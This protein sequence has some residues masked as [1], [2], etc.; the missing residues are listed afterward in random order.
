[1]FGVSQMIVCTGLFGSKRV[2]DDEGFRLAIDDL[3]SVNPVVRHMSGGNATPCRPQ[4]SLAKS[5][6]RSINIASPVGKTGP[7]PLSSASVHGAFAQSMDIGT[8]RSIPCPRPAPAMS[9]PRRHQTQARRASGRVARSRSQSTGHTGAVIAEDLH[10]RLGK[11]TDA[12]HHDVRPGFHSVRPSTGSR[13][14]PR[15]GV[16]APIN[17]QYPPFFKNGGIKYRARTF[18]SPLLFTIAWLRGRIRW[19]PNVFSEQ[20]I[21]GSPV[22]A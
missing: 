21:G 10:H 1:M 17:D 15:M 11:S 6:S 19:S 5:R 22:F 3:Q 20:T 2:L 9:Q 8:T 14:G 18:W 13:Q 7:P 12:K 16:T 4:S